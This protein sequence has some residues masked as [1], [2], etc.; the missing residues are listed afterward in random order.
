MEILIIAVLALV[1]LVVD[2][3]LNKIYKELK[4]LNETMERSATP[5]G[6]AGG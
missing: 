2:W 4:R 3:R 6:R 1:L 5:P